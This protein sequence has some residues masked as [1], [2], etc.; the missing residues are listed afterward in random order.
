MAVICFVTAAISL[1]LMMIAE[2]ELVVTLGIVDIV[3]YL[4]MGS[5]L[6]A[7]KHW[8]FALLATIYSGV[9]TVVGLANDGTPSGI[10]ALAVGIACVG[11]LM[12]ALKAYQDY[13]STGNPPTTP[14]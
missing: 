5:L 6:L 4:S 10:A 8:A 12:K 3:V 11:M 9:W 14:I 1:P 7:T 13:K 2:D